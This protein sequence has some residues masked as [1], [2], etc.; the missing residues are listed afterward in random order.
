MDQVRTD[1]TRHLGGS[2]SPVQRALVER[3]AMLTLHVALFDAHALAGGKMSLQ[4]SQKYLAYSNSLSRLLRH[5]GL[6]AATARG[7]SLGEY[8]QTKSAPDKGARAS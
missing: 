7:V 6:K 3:A 5:L 2:L 4:D 1:L 8:L